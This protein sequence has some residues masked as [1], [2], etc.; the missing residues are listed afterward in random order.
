[1]ST[2]VE[3]MGGDEKAVAYLA[4]AVEDGAEV[5][6]LSRADAERVAEFARAVLG[7]P[8]TVRVS[9]PVR[10]LSREFKVVR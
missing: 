10:V 1:M 5:S 8:A 6:D 2:M 7:V 3:V 4:L 9:G